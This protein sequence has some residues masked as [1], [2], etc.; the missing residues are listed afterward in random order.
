MINKSNS[1]II[2]RYLTKTDTEYKNLLSFS[3]YTS[4]YKMV[5]NT[6]INI[7]IYGTCVFYNIQDNEGFKLCV[8]N[9]SDL[10]NFKILI[11]QRTRCRIEVDILIIENNRKEVFGIWF[12]NKEA[13]IEIYKIIEQKYKN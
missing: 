5:D 7:D 6:W 9:K 1:L 13:L 3:K 2:R 11:D 12:H 8:Y 10:K 4:V